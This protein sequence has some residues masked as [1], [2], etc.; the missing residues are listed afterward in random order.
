MRNTFRRWV[1]PL[2]AVLALLGL[3]LASIRS[4]PE[5]RAFDSRLMLQALVTVD[6]RWVGGALAA[7][8]STY[9][10]R[11][12]R[13]GVL[14]RPVKR[15]TSLRNLLSATVIGFAA[16][17]IFGRAGEM[18]RPYLVARKEGI[19]LSSQVAVWMLERCFD[20]LTLLLTAGFAL[21]HSTAAGRH[22]SP[23]MSRA[24]RLGGTMVALATLGLLVL[25]VGLAKFAEPFAG[26]LLRRLGFLPPVRLQWVERNLR[27]F[28]EGC[29]AI[30]DWRCLAACILYSA[31]EWSLIALCYGAVFNAF[32]GGLRLSL[33]DTLIFMTGVMVGSLVQLPGVGGGIQAAS[34]LVLTEVFALQPELAVSVSLLIWVFTFLVIVP[35]ALLLAGYEGLS[36]RRLRRLGSEG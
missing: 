31:A 1:L 18:V 4:N 16:I 21:R 32:G 20:T 11:A 10:V 34:V 5:W 36:W 9:L 13:W 17:G 23:A 3:L 25:L 28:L 30:R 8:Y 24:L 33:G 19:P 15:R 22:S 12:L 35:P 26:R 6:W 7:I 29:R 2:I 14:T 27:S